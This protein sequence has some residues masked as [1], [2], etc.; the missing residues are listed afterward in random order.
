MS[1]HVLLAGTY[2]SRGSRGI[3]C[4]TALAD[5]GQPAEPVVI[6]ADDPSFMV[7]DHAARFLYCV[8][9]TPGR[10]GQVSAFSF[11]PASREA[12]LL[13]RV[14]AG[15]EDP[16]HITLTPDERFVLVSC[17][18]SG[19]LAVFPRLDDGS[20]GEAVQQIAFDGGSRVHATRQE[21]AHLHS[22]TCSPDGQF[23]FACD[24]G[25]DRIYQFA[26]TGDDNEPL[27]ERQ[28][29]IAPPGSGPRHLKFH[30]E[31]HWAYL[32]GE[33]DGSIVGYRHDGTT[34]VQYQVASLTSTNDDREHGA[35][36]LQFGH[37]GRSLYVTNRG[38]FDELVSLD[39]D[40]EGILTWRGSTST[41]GQLPRHFTVTPD[42]G[43]VLIGNQQSGDVTRMALLPDGGFGEVETLL[44]LDDVAFLHL[45][46]AGSTS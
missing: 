46:A 11:S 5:A 10:I 45:V 24:L 29:I 31:G 22:C 37:D 19:S 17:Y 8:N 32:V 21:K 6:E 9:E 7:L 27:G 28:D 30:P 16:C 34:L 44:N 42:G 1:T 13:S 26:L 43:H 15:G 20:L 36:E 41:G 4:Y 2:T 33:L 18:S 14:S 38:Q 39:I 23:V 12:T 3:Y 35:G 25:N 40:Q